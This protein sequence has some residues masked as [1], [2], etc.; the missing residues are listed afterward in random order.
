[1]NQN[2]RESLFLIFANAA[3]PDNL[4]ENRYKSTLKLYHCHNSYA[5]QKVRLYLKEMN[6]P[7]ESQHIDLLKQEHLTDEYIKINPRGLVP[8][9]DDNGCIILN[10]T[11]IMQYLH[12]NYVNEAS[13][14]L[15]LAKEL[16]DFCKQDESLHD[17]HIRTLSY[18]HLWMT[19]E[20]NPDEVERVLLLSKKY[21]DKARG[22][23]LARA[24][25]RQITE[26]EL[27]CAK[28]QIVAAIDDMEKNYNHSQVLFLAMTTQWQMPLVQQ[29]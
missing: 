6:I 14:D 10:S 9:L 5:S 23:F 12:D 4:N 26:N 29:D 13:P 24:V 28:K 16:Y 22:E 27:A 19:G 25:Q 15:G 2:E 17:P 20:Q 21:P 7:W 3:Q 1:M 11:D 8:A 18:H